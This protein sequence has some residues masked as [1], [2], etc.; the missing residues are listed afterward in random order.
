VQI[1]QASVFTLGPSAA[2]G[3]NLQIQSL[4]AGLPQGTVCGTQVKVRSAGQPHK[5]APAI[6]SAATSW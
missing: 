6:A 5:A 4:T 1:S 3:G 2:I